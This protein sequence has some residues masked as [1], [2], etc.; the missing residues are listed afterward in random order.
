MSKY[1]FYIEA[2]YSNENNYLEIN[3]EERNL[4][5]YNGKEIKIKTLDK[6]K[7][8]SEAK[9]IA[10]ECGIFDEIEE[11]I[12]TAKKVYVNFLI[13][14]NNTDISYLLDKYSK[15]NFQD[16]Y[17]E[18]DSY[19]YK[20]I[21]IEDMTKKDD[22]IY[23]A[24]VNGKTG[25]THFSFK[26]IL[27]MSIDQKLKDSLKINNY[28]KFLKGNNIDSMLDNTLFTSSIEMLLNKEERNQDEINVINEICKYIDMRYETTKNKS[29]LEIKSMIE[30]NKHKSINAKIREIVENN[31]TED[32]KKE[33]YKRVK[34]I[35]QSRTKE[36][37]SSSKNK[38]EHVFTYGILNNIQ[39]NYAKELYKK[40]ITGK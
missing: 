1:K 31:S 9:G 3:E 15:G 30:N 36:I 12:E 16:Y 29:Y 24:V 23:W 38:P 32:E 8:I 27:D 21:V 19:I 17:K 11:C 10:I 20:E 5:T 4:L 28:R 13:R 25:C 22:T 39:I 34:Q 14:L 2:Y 33:N 26:K 40:G 35:T 6:G 37:H 18:A 7:K